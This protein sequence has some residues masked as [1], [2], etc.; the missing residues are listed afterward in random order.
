[1]GD[2]AAAPHAHWVTPTSLTWERQCWVAG[3]HL[4][5][6]AH[7]VP[8]PTIGPSQCWQPAWECW[9]KLLCSVSHHWQRQ[10]GVVHGADRTVDHR[11]AEG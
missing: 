6:C 1:V 2:R 8:G 4:G 5:Q 7:W 3:A 11:L 9:I 10:K